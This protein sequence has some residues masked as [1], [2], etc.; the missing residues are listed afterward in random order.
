LCRLVITATDRGSPPLTG[1]TILTVVVM[2]VNDNSPTIPVQLELTVREDA[3]IGSEIVQVTGNDVDS[4]PALS[5]TLL[6]DG[7]TERTF[8]IL[9]YGGQIWLSK[10]LDYEDRSSFTLT[11]QT[12]DGK[13][14]TRADVKLTLEDVNDNTPEFSKS[15]YQ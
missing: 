11:I 6:V 4:G 7:T 8:S 3:L 12:S 1:S 9:R 10:Q 2:D 14:H 5:Y 13:H 15:F